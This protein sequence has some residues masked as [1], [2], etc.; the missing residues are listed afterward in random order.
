MPIQK[1][2]IVVLEGGAEGEVLGV[3]E[4]SDPRL[5]GGPTRFAAVLVATPGEPESFAVYVRRFGALKSKA[6]RL[7]ERKAELMAEAAE[8]DAKLAEIAGAAGAAGAA[9]AK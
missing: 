8:I 3:L 9:S 2:D 4:V 7:A 1:G 6:A 5:A